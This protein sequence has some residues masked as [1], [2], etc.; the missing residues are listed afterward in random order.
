MSCIF[1]PLH[2]LAISPIVLIILTINILNKFKSTYISL[3]LYKS[4]IRVEFESTFFV[5]DKKRYWFWV[6]FS[7]FVCIFELI[8]CW[9]LG[10]IWLQFGPCDACLYDDQVD[11]VGGWKAKGLQVWLKF[12]WGL[13]RRDNVVAVEE[14]VVGCFLIGRFF[15]EENVRQK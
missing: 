9:K 15:L 2:L 12:F 6:E 10:L 5:E 14:E 7:S 11:A 8:V 1:C 13:K 4:V 3:N